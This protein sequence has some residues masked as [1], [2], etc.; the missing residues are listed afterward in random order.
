[1]ITIFVTYEGDVQ[2]RTLPRS[3]F[4]QNCTG[5]SG[6]FERISAFVPN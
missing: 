3:G 4:R 5:S 1:M 2:Q 6:G